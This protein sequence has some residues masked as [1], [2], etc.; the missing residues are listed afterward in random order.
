[1]SVVSFLS[2][3]VRPRCCVWRQSRAQVR[4]TEQSGTGTT[5]ASE[6]NN[7]VIISRSRSSKLDGLRASSSPQRSS[8]S[9]TGRNLSDAAWDLFRIMRSQHLSHLVAV[10]HVWC[11]TRIGQKTKFPPCPIHHIQKRK[12]KTLITPK[13]PSALTVST[14]MT[15]AA[16]PVSP[17]PL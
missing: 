3:P 14:L 13:G 15:P 2:N 1:M 10:S 4:Q 12:E 17:C 11:Y 16:P 7:T 5:A 9:R 8:L 6:V